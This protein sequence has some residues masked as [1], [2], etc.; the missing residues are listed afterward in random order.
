M[1]ARST[2]EDGFFKEININYFP[3]S[4]HN[5]RSM[6]HIAHLSKNRHNKISFMKSY[7]EYRDKEREK[8]PCIKRFLFF[9][10]RCPYVDPVLYLEILQM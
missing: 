9:F 8:R 7:P 10:S 6:S 5:K 2:N 1:K 3:M 4:V